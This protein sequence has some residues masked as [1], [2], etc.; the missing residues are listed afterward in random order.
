MDRERGRRHGRRGAREC[1]AV[2][3]D[4]HWLGGHEDPQ[5]DVDGGGEDHRDADGDDAPDEA[6]DAVAAGERGADAGDHPAVA[7]A[8]EAVLG[9]PGA[10]ARRARRRSYGRRQWWGR[11]RWTWRFGSL[12]G[13]GVFVRSRPRGPRSMWAPGERRACLPEA[14]RPRPAGPLLV[15]A[16]LTRPRRG[17][18]LAAR[19]LSSR[20]PAISSARRTSPTR[21]TRAARR[22]RPRPRRRPLARALQPRVPA[23]VRR[24]AAPLPADPPAGARRGAAAQDR[25]L[26]RRHLPLRRAESVGSFTTSFSAHLRDV[27]DRLPRGLSAGRQPRR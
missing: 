24:V 10:G 26:G 3:A 13:L 1:R 4:G 22:R 6:V 19:W 9:E 12:V 23:R 17:A 27:A 15:P 7:G 8:R 18:I 16:P 14:A 21:A 20:P 5:R 11:Y 25:P 2:L